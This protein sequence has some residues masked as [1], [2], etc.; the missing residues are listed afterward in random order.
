M[1]FLPVPEKTTFRDSVKK[2]SPPWLQGF[3]GYRLM[4]SIAIQMDGIADMLTEGVLARMPGF[5][6]H[7]A[8]QYSGNDK[9]IL[10]G[11]AESDESYIQRLQTALDVWKIAGNAQSI[12][13]ELAGYVS[14]LTPRFRYVVNGVDESGTRIA[15]WIT[16]EAG[17]VTYF[18]ANPN[19]WDWDG[20]FSQVR[21]WIIVYPGVWTG[22]TWG[23]GDRYND[24]HTWGTSA[25]L[26]QVEDVRSLIAKFKCAGTRELYTIVATS[27]SQFDPTAAPGPPM[28]SGNWN[29]SRNRDPNAFYWPGIL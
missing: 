10:R 5:G 11:F 15:D 16:V 7:D 28:P 26:A 25:T 24:G 18:R 29:D 17:V 12:I 22:R 19:N 23:N 6:T 8:L 27:S 21:F 20:S 9:Q 13:L 4:Y 3:W 1:P 14:P 2:I